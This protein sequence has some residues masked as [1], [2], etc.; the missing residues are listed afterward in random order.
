VGW[1]V[2]VGEKEGNIVG[3]AVGK[4][5]G[6]SVGEA[7]GS[8]ELVELVKPTE[9]IIKESSKRNTD[10]RVRSLHREVK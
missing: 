1:V 3:E 9:Q 7:E 10:Q 5:V 4:N 6:S 8:A 2:V